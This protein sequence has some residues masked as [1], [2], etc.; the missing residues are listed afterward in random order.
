MKHGNAWKGNEAGYDALHY[1]LRAERGRPQRCDVCG[2]E[3]TSKTYDWANMTGHYDDPDD[4]KRMCR[5]CHLK[6]DGGRQ[7]K[8]EQHGN[9]R[10]TWAIVREMRAS[11][12]TGEITQYELGSRY[13]ISRS[14][15]SLIVNN[16]TWKEA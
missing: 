1:R 2:T 6:H 4:Y 5:S 3:D 10:L 9:S 11:W 8:G 14:N 7:V 16:M 13:G 15:V 12:A